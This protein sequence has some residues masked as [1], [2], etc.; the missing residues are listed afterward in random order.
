[1]MRCAGSLFVSVNFLPLAAARA[2][3]IA[4]EV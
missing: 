4:G 1:M 3:N 2:G